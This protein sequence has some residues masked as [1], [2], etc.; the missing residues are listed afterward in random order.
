MENGYNVSS[1]VFIS[2]NPL[3]VPLMPSDLLAVASGLNA[4]LES[5]SLR[6]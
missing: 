4:R 3:A 1:C 5:T 6:K 2:M